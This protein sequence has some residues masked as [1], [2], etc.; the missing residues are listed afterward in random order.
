ME[1]RFCVEMKKNIRQVAPTTSSFTGS[2]SG[3]K[4]DFI[5]QARWHLCLH[6]E[7]HL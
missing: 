7:Y 4:A 6:V 1:Y 5:L 3:A 2:A